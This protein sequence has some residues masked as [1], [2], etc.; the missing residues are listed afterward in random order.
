VL[1]MTTQGFV[2][3]PGDMFLLKRYLETHPVPQ[4]VVIAAAPDDYAVM[5]DPRMVHYYMWNTFRRPDERA[6]LKQYMPTVDDS[7][8]YPAAME[9]QERIVERLITLLRRDPAG[10]SAPPPPPDPNAPVEPV[11]DNEASH[12]AVVRRLESTDLALKPLYRASLAGM[13]R[14][15]AEYGFELD[16]VWAPMPPLIAQQ[17]KSNGELGALDDE[18]HQVFAQNGCRSG[19]IF[20]MNDVQS[21]TDFD[22]GAFHLRGSGWQQRAALVLSRYLRD[23]PDSRMLP[24][25][26]ADGQATADSLRHSGL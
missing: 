12:Y 7:E 21:F 3:L 8:H 15:G 24:R 14:L 23:L 10:F 13:C 16:I 22:T 5:T 20:N 1:N 19:P 11:S 17:R 25:P 2:G 18:I 26:F 9:L 4:H 6:F